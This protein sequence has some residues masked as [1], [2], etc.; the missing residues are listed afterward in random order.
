MK[1]TDQTLMQQMH[2]SII[3]IERRKQLLGLT[4][5]DLTGLTRV[6]DVIRPELEVL[7]EDFYDFQTSVP[8]IASLIGDADTLKRLKT[9]QFQY[10]LD[11]FSCCY[12]S[13][14]VNNRLRIGLVHKR[15]GVEPRFYLAAMHHL[16]THLFEYIRSA[17]QDQASVEQIVCSLEKL[18]MF[19]VT[20]IFETYV[21]GLMNEVN[22]SKDKLQQYAS[23]L[24]VHAQE[25]ENLSKIDPLTGLLNVRQLMPI[26]NDILSSAQRQQAPITVVFIDINDFKKI[27]DQF[28]HLFGDKIIQAVASA[29]R[30]YARDEDYCFRY[31]G[32]EFLVIMPNCTEDNVKDCFIPRVLNHLM[33]LD[34]PISLSVGSYQT[35]AQTGYMDSASLIGSADCKMYEVKKHL[36]LQKN[37]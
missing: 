27:N 21:W 15:I 23:A 7:I 8:E 34:Q 29:L 6:R 22:S 24:G 28:G 13:N 18:F 5:Q 2:I 36:K 12:D 19:D 9:A 31:G 35:D 33:S 14:Y 20:L 11:L 30:Q 26:L 4:E 32:D 17:I 25:M 1:P 37:A 10:I 3:D 16:K